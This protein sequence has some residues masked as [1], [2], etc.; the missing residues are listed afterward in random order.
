MAGSEFLMALTLGV[1]A[2][3]ELLLA[4]TELPTA[5]IELS[6]ALTNGG[7]ALTK[8]PLATIELALAVSELPL[9]TI[10]SPRF[11]LIFFLPT[12]V[13]STA[14]FAS[15][16]VRFFLKESIYFFAPNKLAKFPPLLNV[17][18]ELAVFQTAFCYPSTN[19]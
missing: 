10:N 5:V 14:H 17:L 7:M 9:A 6:L 4:L 1:L 16:F 11:V 12:C 13:K 18:S 2:L 3:T 19:N 8:L 15:P